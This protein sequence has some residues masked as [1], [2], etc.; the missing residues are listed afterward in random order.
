MDLSFLDAEDDF[1]DEVVQCSAV[2]YSA[3]LRSAVCVSYPVL[4]G[5][6]LSVEVSV[7]LVIL[8]I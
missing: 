5:P 8:T 6:C 4:S 1:D 3:V 2:Q 7:I